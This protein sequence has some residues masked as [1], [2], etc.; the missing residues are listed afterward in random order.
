MTQKEKDKYLQKKTIGVLG[1]LDFGGLELKCIEHGIDDYAVFVVNS[2][3]GNPSV[4]RCVIQYAGYKPY[5]KVYGSRVYMSE[6]MRI[7]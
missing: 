7:Q 1:T 5:F 4:H 3:F 6:I 2:V